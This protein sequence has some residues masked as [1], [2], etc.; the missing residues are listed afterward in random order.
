MPSIRRINK[1]DTLHPKR[2]M[3][4]RELARH[5]SGNLQRE[6]SCFANQAL[7]EQFP[8]NVSVGANE[9]FVDL[10]CNLET[11]SYREIRIDEVM[12]SKCQ[13]ISFFSLS[14]RECCDFTPHFVGELNGEMNKPTDPDYADLT[15]WLEIVTN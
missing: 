15:C 6:N 9:Q 1:I 4:H 12:C 3:R 2:H 10:S 11:L 14:C 5:I 13:R 7:C 8:K